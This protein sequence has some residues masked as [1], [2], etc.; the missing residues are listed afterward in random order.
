MDSWSKTAWQAAMPTIERIK[1]LPFLHE[2]ADGTLPASKFR[3]YISQDR[4]YL[5]VYTRVLAHI[6]SRLPDMTDVGTFLSFAVDSVAVEKALHE[7][8]DP[9]KDIAMSEACEFYTSFLRAQSQADIAVEAAAV[10]PCFW[11]YQEVGKYIH[12]TARPD[13]NPYRAWIRT[14]ADP[15]FDQSTARAIAICDKLA[16]A[17]TPA[18]RRQMTAAF[19]TATRL[20]HLFW[21]SAYEEGRFHI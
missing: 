5:D 20:E 17:A 21:Q 11:V 8:F 18:I 12:A 13:G 16:A 2:L 4:L 1:V 7:Q 9:D 10:L 15:A 19:A 3:F 14:Y 6:A